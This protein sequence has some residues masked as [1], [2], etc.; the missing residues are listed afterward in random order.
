MDG[1]IEALNAL[2]ADRISAYLAPD[3]SVFVPTV[4][5]GRVSGK[6]AVDAIFRDFVAASRK[7]EA[8]TSIVPEDQVIELGGDVAVVSFTVAG[9]GSLARRTFVFR[10]TGGAWLISHF[11]ASNL[12]R[13]R[14]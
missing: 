11:H 4:S 1:F 7:S 10:R 5:P 9:K 14:P 6:A 8:R 3:I 2:D 13:P 12:P